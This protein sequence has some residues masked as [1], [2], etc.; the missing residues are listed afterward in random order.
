MLD[1]PTSGLDPGYERTLMDLLRSLA[2]G[3]RTVIVVTHSVQSLMLCD[4]VLFLAPGGPHRVLRSAAARRSRSSGGRTS[5][6][7]SRT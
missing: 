3:G 1:E 4:R 2:D 6:R 5:S 7:C